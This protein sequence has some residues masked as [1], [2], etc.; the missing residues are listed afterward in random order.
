MIHPSYV[1]MIDKINEE[2]MSDREEAPLVTSRY[3]IVLATARRAR[4]LIA[5]AKPMVRSKDRYERER[6]SLSIAVDELYAG[7]VHIL[8]KDAAAGA[9][10]QTEE[11]AAAQDVSENSAAPEA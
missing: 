9:D 10:E 2:Q 4:Q 7:K 3:S 11:S 8:R 5:G 1:E 6:K